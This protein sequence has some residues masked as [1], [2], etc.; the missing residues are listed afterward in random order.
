MNIL[1]NVRMKVLMLAFLTVGM[2]TPSW[3][4]SYYVSGG[5]SD[6]GSG[7]EASPWKTVGKANGVARAGDTIFIK[8]G[9]S[10]GAMSAISGSTGSYVTYAAYGTGTKPEFSNANISG[11][12]WIKFKGLK[13]RSRSSGVFPVIIQNNSSYIWVDSCEVYAETSVYAVLRIYMNSHH[14]KVTNST[15]AHKY[16]SAQND[17]LNLKLNANNNL[18]EGNTIGTGTHYALT[19]EGNDASH[20]TYTANNNIIRNN[21]ITNPQGAMV[22]L[23][24]DSNRNV[25]EGNKIT[26]GKSSSYCNN[27][28]TSFKNVSSYNIIRNNIIHTNTQ[29]TGSGLH[30]MV[31]QYGS[32]PPNIAVGNRSYNNL[33]TGIV[34]YP[35]ALDNNEAQTPENVA[36]SNNVFKNNLVYNNGSKYQLYIGNWPM[37]KDNFFFNNIFYNSLT[38]SVL[39]IK[40]ALSNVAT[41]ESRDPA[42]FADNLQV[43][44]KY[45]KATWKP[46]AG[47]P[48]IDAGTFLTK[49]KSG[50]TGTTV[51][52]E[53]ASYF[54]DGF[55]VADGDTVQIG[56]VKRLVVDVNYSTNVITV[57]SPATWTAGTPVSLPYA[58]SKP[59]IGPS[60]LMN[61]LPAPR[62]LIVR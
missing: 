3:A 1:K 50:S 6:T 33:I 10:Y 13:F 55:G 19:L 23:M 48:V 2:S 38:Q 47:S 52:L 29:S 43:D 12:S 61:V 46:L 26:G 20:P 14:N 45:D 7:T 17:A 18:I 25:V 22:E 9:Y 15:I 37:I 40:G 44:P 32:A 42:H 27:S 8:S 41:A 16:F 54:H 49:V 4:A 30:S 24:S 5:G 34:S 35:L 11:K 36:A 21:I 59:D 51:S 28:P 53:D 57:D 62:N 31:Y 39:S 56:S 58:G 60:E